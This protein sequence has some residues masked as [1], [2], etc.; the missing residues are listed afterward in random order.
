MWIHTLSQLAGYSDYHFIR[1]FKPYTGFTCIQYINR[2]RLEAAS[3]M[4]THT[5]LSVTAI[6]M[7]CGYDNVSYFIRT[8]KKL[9][10]ASP[11]KYRKA[12]NPL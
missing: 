7:E 6:A 10:K 4:L 9:H 5:D 3:R 8:F 2:I 1:F 12:M 11:D